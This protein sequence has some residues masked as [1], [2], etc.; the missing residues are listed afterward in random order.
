MIQ[1]NVSPVSPLPHRVCEG[2]GYDSLDAFA[3]M[4]MDDDGCQNPQAMVC[5]LKTMLVSDEE[6]FSCYRSESFDHPLI[7]RHS[8]HTKTVPE[9]W[10]YVS[11]TIRKVVAMVFDLDG[12]SNTY[13]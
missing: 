11:R 2:A 4:R 9:R 7:K 8:I 12:I 3:Q 1:P 13:S 5:D 10:F 6:G